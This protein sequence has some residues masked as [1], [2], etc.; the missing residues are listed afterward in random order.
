MGLERVVKRDKGGVWLG[1]CSGLAGCI[2]AG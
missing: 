2:V 1:F